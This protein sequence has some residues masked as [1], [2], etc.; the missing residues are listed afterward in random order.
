MD[1]KG[2]TMSVMPVDNMLTRTDLD[3]LPDDG[4]RHELIDGHYVDV[5]RIVG[6]QSF[7]VTKPVPVTLNPAELLRG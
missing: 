5:A 2:G 6:D 3:A 1:K 7:S 4:L